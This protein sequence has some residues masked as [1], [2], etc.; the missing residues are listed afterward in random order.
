MSKYIDADLYVEMQLY[1]DEYEEW[2]VW[3]GTIEDL[4]NQW[5]EEGCPP[6]IEVSEDCIS[7]KWVISFIDAGHLRNP[8][9]KCF[10]END[11]VE[12]VKNAPSVTP[13]KPQKFNR[14]VTEM[15]DECGI[16]WEYSDNPEDIK[17][18]LELFDEAFIEAFGT[19]PP[20]TPTERTGEWIKNDDFTCS[21]CGYHMIVGGGAYNYCPNCGADMRGEK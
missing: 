7:R 18:T 3:N 6:P 12:L 9:E 10:S 1:D 20:V 15:L 14:P 16:E 8:N 2:G 13:T 11:V 4:L 21:A 19:R 5:T 17:R